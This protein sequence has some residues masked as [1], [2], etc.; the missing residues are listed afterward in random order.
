MIQMFFSDCLN[1]KSVETHQ[2]VAHYEVDLPPC[3]HANL[4]IPLPILIDQ[5]P[6]SIWRVN[7]FI[8]EVQN[9]TE[10]I[11]HGYF[12]PPVVPEPELCDI[13]F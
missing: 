9:L 5:S 8:T 2:D 10:F 12:K 6:L 3:C 13:M 4:S 11:N 7:Y 1:L